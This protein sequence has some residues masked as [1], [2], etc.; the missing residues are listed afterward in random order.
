MLAPNHNTIARAVSTSMRRMGIQVKTKAVHLGAPFR[1]GGKSRPP[2]LA[3]P[4]WAAA[5]KRRIRTL[6]LGRRLGLHVTKTG[7]T[8]VASF[9]TA[10][11]FPAVSTLRAMR[12][13]TAQFYGSAAGTSTTARLAL[14]SNDPRFGIKK[15]AVTA[16]LRAVWQANLPYS[17]LYAA[18]AHARCQ[19]RY[20]TRSGAAGAYLT[21]IA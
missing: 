7:L 9:G 21:A 13:Y 3:A 4:R 20:G 18:W 10:V 14:L 15:K 6:R 16:W 5:A 8:L 11:T 1:L 17:T 2:P 19:H 12:R